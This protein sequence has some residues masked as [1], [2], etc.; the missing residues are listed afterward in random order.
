M[1]SYLRDT[2]LG[3]TPTPEQT[4]SSKMPAKSDKYGYYELAGSLKVGKHYLIKCNKDF[5]K[6]CRKII[7]L[8]KEKKKVNMSMVKNTATPTPTLAQTPAPTPTPRP[9]VVDRK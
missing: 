2:T 4:T 7:R 9:T 8:E 5:Y 6:G 1:S 3:A